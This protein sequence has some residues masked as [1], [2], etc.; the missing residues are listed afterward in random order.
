MKQFF[1]YTFYAKKIFRFLLFLLILLV[2]MPII[3]TP[4]V[5]AQ[6]TKTGNFFT[7]RFKR[8]NKFRRK[9]KNSTAF[10]RKPFSCD[11]IGKTKVEQI[12]VS[13]KQ[14]RRWEEER[15]V[16]AEQQKLKEQ[17][18]AKNNTKTQEENM[19]LSA[20]SKNNIEEIATQKSNTLKKETETKK[21]K[22]EEEKKESI[23]TVGWY[24]SEKPDVPKISPI[25]INQKNEVIGQKNKE[26]LEIAA[27][28]SRLGYTITLESNNQKQLEIVKQ[29]LLSISA[30][31]ETIKIKPSETANQNEVNIKIEK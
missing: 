8:K 25:R 2:A 7:R 30:E 10:Q 24:S 29:Y 26:E 17:R 31:E 1:T 15:L 21:E 9:S 18:Q 23:E 6:T 28:Y 22:T 19:V 3:E 27:K 20:S 5:E 11:D 14:L 12:K 13:K 4:K 16:K